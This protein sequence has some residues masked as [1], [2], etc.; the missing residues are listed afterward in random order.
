MK[1]RKNYV[2]GTS[3]TARRFHFYSL[4]DETSVFFFCFLKVS[5]AINKIMMFCVKGPKYVSIRYKALFCR[6]AYT[7]IRACTVYVHSSNSA[8]PTTQYCLLAIFLT[9]RSEL[10]ISQSITSY[11]KKKWIKKKRLQFSIMTI[12]EFHVPIVECAEWT[13]AWKTHT[14][15]KKKYVFPIKTKH[16]YSD[17]LASRAPRR[18]N[19][20]VA[21]PLTS[22][23][24]KLHARNPR[25]MRQ[26]VTFG[27]E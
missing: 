2:T 11:N 23:R 17:I 1:G 27:H 20:V 6:I 26:K 16:Y 18:E 5:A 10:R 7:N 13:C 3:C 15:Y 4:N 22:W 21:Q 12:D 8:D 19:I 9:K 14:K 25:V 24:S